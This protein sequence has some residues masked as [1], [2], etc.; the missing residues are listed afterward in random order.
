MLSV[1]VPPISV[2]LLSAWFKRTAAREKLCR[3]VQNATD[4]IAARSRHSRRTAATL[5]ALR[6]SASNTRQ[7]LQ[8]WGPVD[9]FRAAWRD[10]TEDQGS[11]LSRVLSAAASG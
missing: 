5:R 10:L 9:Q 8:F 2:G 4:L 3:L 7:V 6:A 1:A 11:I